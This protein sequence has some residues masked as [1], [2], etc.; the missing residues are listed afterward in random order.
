MAIVDH[1]RWDAT[2]KDYGNS[3]I[4][5]IASH[6]QNILDFYKFSE[7]KARVEFLQ[8][9]KLQVKRYGSMKDKLLF[10][11]KI[12]SFHKD[13]ISLS[14]LASGKKLPEFSI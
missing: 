2:D 6:F 14:M 8:L 5:V 4:H 11:N 9:R 7:V 3:E 10:W 12:F 13:K 1:T